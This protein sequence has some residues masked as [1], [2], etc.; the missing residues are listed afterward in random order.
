MKT[1]R[2]LTAAVCFCALGL[3]PLSASAAELVLWHS[4][5]AEEKA[6]MD[7][8]VAQYNAANAAKGITVKALPV[9]YD[10]FADKITA[11]VPR[12]KGP[13]LFIF[14]QDRLGGWIEAGNTIE[15]IDFFVDDA[16]KKRF[17]PTTLDAMTYRGTL[18]GLPLNYKVTTL[19][20]NKKL[21]PTPPKTSA[22]MVQIAKKITNK[23]AGKFGLA[24]AYGDFYYHAALMNGFGGGVFDAKFT[25]TMN[26]PANVKSIDLLM[27]WIDK[28]G[29]LPAEPSTALVTSLFNDGKTGM[30]I[31]GPW[32]LGEIAKGIE[33]GLA[34]LPTLDE[35][36]GKPMRPWMTVEGVYVTAPSQNKEAAFDF[37]KFLTDT[38]SAKVLALEGRQSPGNAQVYTDAQVSKDPQLKP[39]RDQVDTAV[40]MPNAPEMTM[41]WSPA[42]T[43]M[44]SILKKTATPKAALDTAQKAV[45][46]DIAGLRK[47]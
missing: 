19:I 35:A 9:P 31:S 42:T 46:K 37:A 8:L 11:T 32:F 45:A 25:P 7:K 6:A 41:I 36:D 1:L 28:D 39:F 44:N 3:L 4:Y 17:I 30:V 27:K 15:P 26:S 21:V 34:P 38:A 47:K 23:G 22:E 29:I 2:L 12:G 33:Y 10:A 5:R 43:A 14:A 40:P 20:Y 13:D 24:Y 18:Y 16:L